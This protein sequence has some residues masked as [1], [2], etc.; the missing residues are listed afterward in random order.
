MDELI[1]FVLKHIQS[2]ACLK[3][4]KKIEVMGVLR[5]NGI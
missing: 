3:S 1:V 5:D 2:L 4:Q